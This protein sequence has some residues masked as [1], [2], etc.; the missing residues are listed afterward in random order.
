MSENTNT[1]SKEPKLKNRQNNRFVVGN[2]IRERDK[3]LA[4]LAKIL[5]GCHRREY[6]INSPEESTSGYNFRKAV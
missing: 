5:L 6:G 4:S 1:S 3:N 2:R